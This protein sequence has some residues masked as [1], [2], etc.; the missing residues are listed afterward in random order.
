MVK[1]FDFSESSGRYKADFDSLIDKLKEKLPQLIKESISLTLT[2]CVGEQND[3]SAT[4][5]WTEIR[6]N[7][8]S[9]TNAVKVSH[10]T[11]DTKDLESICKKVEPLKTCPED[12]NSLTTLILEIKTELNSLSAQIN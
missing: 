10:P 3:P 11:L 8:L 12:K 9:I 7:I 6:R 5:N 4:D 1:N 2:L